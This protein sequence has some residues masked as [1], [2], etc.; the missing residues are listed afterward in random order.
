MNARGLVG[1]IVAAL[2]AAL[3]ARGGEPPHGDLGI[4]NLVSAGWDEPWTKRVRAA[5]DMALLR[6]QTN[7]LE[8]ELRVNYLFAND[9]ASTTRRRQHETEALVAYGINRRLMF[10]VSTRY[11]AFVGRGGKSDEDGVSGALAAR[12]Q[13]VDTADS[14]YAL[15]VRAAAP[16]RGT[17]EHRTTLSYGVAGFEDLTDRLGLRRVGLY[18][19]VLFDT[20]AGPA[21]AAARR[22]DVS[23]DLSVAKTVTP[24]NSFVFGG[25]T[26]FLETFAQ[27]DL[28][29]AHA[30]RTAWSFTPGTRFDVGRGNWL[31][32]GIDVPIRT[33]GKPYDFAYR[34][35][36]ILNF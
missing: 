7:F 33:S 10:A 28:D 12:L 18:G 22:H 35:T 24:R 3:P 6:V 5:P 25:L 20:A 4:A 31:M 16:N 26:L 30:G 23:Y 9:L 19:H 11:D 34:T 17:G 36:Y 1:C 14:S 21:A 32:G 27:T 13:L 2:L 8:R 15:N 29:G